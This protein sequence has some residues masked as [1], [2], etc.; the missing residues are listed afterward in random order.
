[1]VKE[2]HIL[3]IHFLGRHRL[4]CFP[5]WS[6]RFPWDQHD[7]QGEASQTGQLAI[8]TLTQPFTFSMTPTFGCEDIR[9]DMGQKCC[10]LLMEHGPISLS[11]FRW[12]VFT[13][14]NGWES[15]SMGT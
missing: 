12:S 2:V 15:V 6:P 9:C 7:S 1:M 11:S 5:L 14:P 10:N 13:Q 8:A 4:Y 3:Q